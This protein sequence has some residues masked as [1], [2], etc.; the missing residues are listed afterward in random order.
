MILGSGIQV[1]LKIGVLAILARL[2]SPDE[3]GV[4]GIALIVVEFSKMLA[5]LGVGPAL[6]QRKELDRQHLTTGFSVSLFMGVFFA[7]L[8]ILTAPYLATFFRMDELT[9][10][11]RVISLVFLIDSFTLIAQ[12]LMQ[13]NMKF[14][15]IAIVEVSSYAFG[16][17][18][19]G[20]YFA[21]SGWGVWSLVAAN[22][23]QS[24]VLTMLLVILQPF[25]KRLGFDLKSFKDL[26]Y[27]GGGMTIGKMANFLANQGDKIVI[28]RTLGAAALGIYGR[29]YQFMVMPAGLFGKALDKAL[30]PAMAKVQDDKERLA[31]AYL[32]GVSLI[33]LAAIPLSSVI[34]FLGPEIVS[35]LLG[36]DWT[37]VVL[38]LQILGCSLLFR[39]G[40]KMS[41]SLARATGAVYRRAWRQLVYAALV[42]AGSYF[43][44]FW[45]IKGVA[46]G[47]AL[48]LLAN[49]LLMAQLSLKLT[50][51]SWAKILK[52]HQYGLVLGVIIAVVCY[53]LV[54]VCRIN[55]MPDFLTLIITLVGAGIILLLILFFLPNL[56]IN[57]EIKQLYNMLIIKRL[58]NMNR[59]N[60]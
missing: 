2:V 60:V 53:I 5:H 36:P 7:A 29:A 55:L 48:A 33:G 43:G 8:L 9:K 39:M 10:V 12:A 24:V 42:L 15:L 28:G 22:L 56:I 50:S 21:Y 20:I 1:V 51:T 18:V 45:G 52:A 14:K 35:V 47:V 31:K 58:K 23:S 30:F 34:V 19:V 49:F 59:K 57:D 4:M 3:F 41:D 17:G 54:S 40:S 13:R 25:P 26:I 27:F 46:L 6:V 11:I 37:G 32:T 38:P 16:D 44:H